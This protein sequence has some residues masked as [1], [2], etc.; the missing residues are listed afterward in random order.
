MVATTMYGFESIL[1][2]ELVQLGAMHIKK[3]IRNVSFVGDTGFMYKANL[4]LRT[5]L[6]IL[7]PVF[8][9]KFSNEEDFYKK[10]YNHNWE[11][12]MSVDQTFMVQA[13][14]FQSVFTHSQY[15][16]LKTKDALVDRFR[17]T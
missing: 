6:S 7:K 8:N 14:I 17:N 1:E 16:A 5:A 15:V 10:L 3:G 9:F 13:T 2:K 12:Y 4:S 11:E